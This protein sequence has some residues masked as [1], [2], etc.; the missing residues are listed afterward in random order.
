MAGSEENALALVDLINDCQNQ[1]LFKAGDTLPSDMVG[2]IEIILEDGSTVDLL[3]GDV[4]PANSASDVYVDEVTGAAACI[5]K[6]VVD[7]DLY[8][9]GDALPADMIGTVDIVLADGTITTLAAG[10]VVP[11]NSISDVIVDE[12][13][14]AA[15][16]IS[17]SVPDQDLFKAGDVLPSDMAQPVEIA[18]DDGTTVTLNA[19]DAIPANSVSTVYV[20]EVTSQ[21][22]CIS[23]SIADQ[24]LFKAG[25]TL[26]DDMIGAI[27]IVLNDGNTVVLSAGD[28]VPANSA[29]SVIVDEVTGAPECISKSIVDQDLFKAGDTLPADMVSTIDILLD[30]GTFATL[31]A[32]DPMPANSASDVYVD[33]STGEASCISKS[34]PPEAE[35]FEP[36]DTL[37]ADMAAPI[38]IVLDDGS[39]V[40][41]NAGEVVP[42]NSASD[43]FVDEVTGKAACI[44]KFVAATPEQ[45]LFKAGDTLPSDL[46]GTVS[47]CINVDTGETADLVADSVLPLDMVGC[48]TVDEV[49]GEF[50]YDSGKSLTKEQLVADFPEGVCDP[51]V[52][53]EVLTAACV[54]LN[55]KDLIP[56]VIPTACESA[57]ETGIVGTPTAP[58][59]NLAMTEVANGQEGTHIFHPS[60]VSVTDSP[61]VIAM[62]ATINPDCVYALHVTYGGQGN[63]GLKSPTVSPASDSTPIYDHSVMNPSVWQSVFLY[64]AANMGTPVTLDFLSGTNDP[65]N[66]TVYQYFWNEICDTNGLPVVAGNFGAPILSPS[67]VIEGEVDGPYNTGDCDSLIFGAIRHVDHNPTG[68]NGAGPIPTNGFEIS[69]EGTGYT[70][71]YDYTSWNNTNGF[72]HCNLGSTSGLMQGGSGDWTWT[73]YNQG[74]NPADY[75]AGIAAL[76]LLSCGPGELATVDAVETCETISENTNC[77]CDGVLECIFSGSVKLCAGE[78]E[79]LT[80]YP[81][82]NGQPVLS[83]AVSASNGECIDQAV[84]FTDLD[85]ANILAPN[86]APV[87]TTSG[88]TFSGQ[89]TYE[90]TPHKLTCKVIPV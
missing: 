16:C 68:A 5:S 33:E 49:T 37:P 32:G 80:A 46:V 45:E 31:A 44:S 38:D 11:A 50:N 54:K 15:S 57:G 77:L 17:K 62:P 76:P 30:D 86:S 78:G 58:E 2:A 64:D 65:V 55:L 25:D 43:V 90:T 29:S 88:W 87:T 22:A 56:V 72:F 26:P 48:V 63:L 66:D 75:G 61:D 23:K 7:Q 85:L 19:G 53:V 52:P 28:L 71:V 83:Q 6:S 59:F 13:T 24:D 3:A 9:P 70:E 14:S 4:V 41:L 1:D 69:N 40:T 51:A 27:E 74:T 8:K 20:D 60:I 12:A 34:A 36:G 21:P 10:D 39:I 79:T 67:D 89:G 82:I 47:V 35:L 18:L 81:V 84:S 42:A 73:P